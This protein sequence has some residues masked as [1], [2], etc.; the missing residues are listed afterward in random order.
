MGR[1]RFGLL[2]LSLVG[3][4][5]VPVFAM[6]QD[7]GKD[8][9]KDD[10]KEPVKAKEVVPAEKKEAADQAAPDGTK[11][12]PAK[13][14]VKPEV[15]TPTP[16]PMPVDA[17]TSLTM[18]QV[19]AAIKA[20]TDSTDLDDETKATI[21]KQW[22]D[23]K[24]ELTTQA[25]E[26]AETA[27][28]QQQLE[29]LPA[30]TARI[31]AELDAAA[32]TPPKPFTL[33]LPASTTSKQLELQLTAAK[34]DLASRQQ[35]LM[36]LEDQLKVLKDEPTK[37]RDDLKKVQ[38]ELETVEKNLA[39]PPV[40]GEKPRLTAARKAKQEATK[41]AR[42]ASI[43]RIEQQLLTYDVRGPYLAA[44]REQAAAAVPP[45]SEKVKII[46]EALT[47]L[48]KE[49]MDQAAKQAEIARIEAMNKDPEIQKL[50]TANAEDAKQNAA[51]SER[52]TALD[53]SVADLK[54]RLDTMREELAAAEKKVK[55]R[56][57]DKR[58]A[59]DLIKRRRTLPN[60]RDLQRSMNEMEQ[61]VRD[62]EAV[63]E[64]L[65][66]QRGE[67]D[68]FEDKVK[69]TMS[70]VASNTTGAQKAQ[71]EAEVRK[72]LTTQKEL[73]SK[74]LE[75]YGNLYQQTRELEDVTQR[76][77]EQ[78]RKFS[79]FIDENLLWIADAN[80]IS[81]SSFRHA[82]SAVLWLV[83]PA[84]WTEFGI[85]LK[86]QVLAAAV[87]SVIVLVIF[88]A[89]LLLR[90]RVHSALANIDSQLKRIDTD[91]FMLT[92]RAMMLT[93]LLALPW[94]VLVLY[95]SILVQQSWNISEFTRA[96]A[97]GLTAAAVSYYML[98]TLIHFLKPMGVAEAHL[99]WTSKSISI[100]RNNL[101]WLL[102]FLTPAAYILT[103]LMSYDDDAFADSLARLTYIGFM[104][105][106]A[107]FLFRVLH[108]RK[109]AVA[110][111]VA[112]DPRSMLARTRNIWF[113]V[114]LLMPLTPAVLAT[115]GYFYT[116]RQIGGSR[117]SAS[118]WLLL[119]V[120]TLHS[121]LLRWLYV[122]QRKLALQNA[123]EKREA[124][125]ATPP[126]QGNKAAGDAA[127]EAG[128]ITVPDAA[129]DLAQINEQTRQIVRALFAI[130]TVVSLYFIWSGVLPAL[131]V[132]DQVNLWAHSINP[133]GTPA[134]IT[135]ASVL[136][137]ILIAFFTAVASKNVPGLLEITVLKRT[138]LDAG[139]RYA[140]A[141]ITRYVISA[142]GIAIAFQAVGIGWSS[143]QWLIAAV[144][145]GLGFGLQEIFANFVSGLIILFE[146]PI[147]VGDTVTVGGVTGTV[148]RIRIRATTIVD[149]DRKELIIP[150]K[151]F[152]TGQ[153]VNWSL[154]DSITRIVIPVG[155]AYG[156]DLELVQRLLHE[157]I[158]N[159]P[160]ILEEPKPSVI[161]VRLGESSLDFE[162][163]V[164]VR[165]LSDRLPTS[166]ALL[167][168]INRSFRKHNVEIPFPQRDLHVRTVSPGVSFVGKKEISNDGDDGSNGQ[169]AS[170]ERTGNAGA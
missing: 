88:G 16:T 19:D 92:P 98:R 66:T 95:F 165:A 136:L 125:A 151:E 89:L 60:E 61:S 40:A 85:T 33:D 158:K 62:I 169:S 103:A 72:L 141:T 164:F 5:W 25:T 116:A 78:S 159:H 96:S 118:M 36:Q 117:L 97:R 18:E 128:I 160:T 32:Q 3:S 4:L 149:W 166:H 26:K 59:R 82:G 34:T 132:L 15:V 39:L 113:P 163:R 42:R 139:G 53:K 12:E 112:D 51:L 80:P 109:G 124:R 115:I 122:A 99:R 17:T 35:T 150:N 30:E 77:I 143:V 84:H 135:L 147:R 68:Q 126:A 110:N 64:S 70:N 71:I 87:L 75:T 105:A 29:T 144:S 140:F 6:A 46:Q 120:L 162:V 48:V 31:K 107:I 133:D 152:I 28:A 73:V 114:A 154:T 27:K 146:R 58:L 155:V 131:R 161:F 69:A 49:E 56:G 79:Q 102:L 156:S 106:I 37:L 47:K 20:T 129:M 100:L 121:L 45:A 90:R 52:K 44:L 67:L 38:M 9:K 157:V 41:R 168:A 101:I 50:T 170:S 55:D 104:I 130:V 86:D 94:P 127:S 24:S 93:L 148:S 142:A 2:V 137:A 13:E 8:E 134:Y 138:P 22:T 43:A 119:L 14:P 91:H 167:E 11:T 74:Q 123:R 21:T 65:Q 63:Q 108:P 145:L 81:L 111:S 7:Q 153:I 1:F 76:M 23:A 57:I 10:N 54:K 83:S